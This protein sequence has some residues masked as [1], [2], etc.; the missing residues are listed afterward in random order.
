MIMLRLSY[1]ST[2]PVDKAVNTPRVK[3]HSIGF[4]FFFHRLP[5]F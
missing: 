3:A 4:L 1:S 2:I 5:I